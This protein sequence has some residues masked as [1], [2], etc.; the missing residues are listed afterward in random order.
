MSEE[1]QDSEQFSY[2]S[3][4][5][6]TDSVMS[7]KFFDDAL[8]EWATE[9]DKKT[10]IRFGKPY[11][12]KKSNDYE[13]PF[14][15]DHS[16]NYPAGYVACFDKDTFDNI[17]S[18]INM[19]ENIPGE[20]CA[21]PTST[22]IHLS[23]SGSQLK[24]YISKKRDDLCWDCGD[25]ILP[26]DAYPT[27]THTL[28]PP[29]I[30]I[31]HS[32]FID[33][34]GKQHVKQEKICVG[35]EFSIEGDGDGNE[36]PNTS[37]SI[38]YL[39]QGSVVVT[40]RTK[41][42]CTSSD[43]KEMS[44][45]SSG[46]EISFWNTGS[47]DDCPIPGCTDPDACNYN[48]FASCEDGSCEYLDCLN[49]PSVTPTHTDE[50][51]FIR[52][53]KCLS[54]EGSTGGGF[55]AEEV[56]FKHSIGASVLDSEGNILKHGDVVRDKSEGKVYN[57]CFIMEFSN[58]P[59]SN[60]NPNGNPIKW[61][62]RGDP[63]SELSRGYICPDDINESCEREGCTFFL[64]GAKECSCPGEIGKFHVQFKSTES[65]PN[66]HYFYKNG[67]CY[68][69]QSSR[70]NVNC[71]YHAF[72]FEEISLS[73][74][75]YSE[76]SNPCENCQNSYNVC[77]AETPTLT[78]TPLVETWVHYSSIECLEEDYLQDGYYYNGCDEAKWGK[79][80]TSWPM[81]PTNKGVFKSS[82]GE[83]VS[84]GFICG[85]AASEKIDKITEFTGTHE[86]YLADSLPER[87]ISKYD[88]AD[89]CGC[90]C[91]NC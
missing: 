2:L 1:N 10:I 90:R 25:P 67:K 15:K 39:R 6:D 68:S 89:G 42:L 27:P 56:Y 51:F 83:S 49:D 91:N 9:E 86:E 35:E 65:I 66:G 50:G 4:G 60:I 69:V 82:F 74:T 64:I 20:S 48:E 85:P 87:N 38:K 17:I 77:P 12:I 59:G 13:E 78:I 45:S 41:S 54:E 18:P 37:F 34:F 72:E 7:R 44:S 84:D 30:N 23:I 75:T 33:A 32:Y 88:S 43:F 53:T 29:C 11:E 26:P 14:T 55:N 76:Q 57:P 62:N 31:R 63:Y 3:K 24:P 46:E 58:E 73:E 28:P 16:F 52:L 5:S 19:G 22:G 70:K 79:G 36:F 47:P 80:R 40:K 21:T 81:H 71:N 61:V 8:K